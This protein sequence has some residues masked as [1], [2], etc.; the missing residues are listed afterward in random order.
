MTGELGAEYRYLCTT[1]MEVLGPR[2][3][4]QHNGEC[5]AVAH[6]TR[7]D[8]WL[9][10]ETERCPEC[11]LE[12]PDVD[13]PPGVST[14]PEWHNEGAEEVRMEPCEHVVTTEAIINEHGGE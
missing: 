12:E 11:G 8:M 10:E 2:E 7:L 14:V 1:C 4:G 13:L 9:T 6:L 3:V 5:A